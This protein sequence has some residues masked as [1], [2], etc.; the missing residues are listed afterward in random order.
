MTVYELNQSQMNDLRVTI[1]EERGMPISW[2][3]IA[4]AS[5]TISDEEVY[6]RFSGYEFTEEDF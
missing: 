5:S 2:D 6:N 3:D 1:M 4:D